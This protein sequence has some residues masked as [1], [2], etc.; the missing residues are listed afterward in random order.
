MGLLIYGFNNDFK[1]FLKNGKK[2]AVSIYIYIHTVCA[3]TIINTKDCYF[4]KIFH[5]LSK[6]TLSENKNKQFWL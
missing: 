5:I 2:L 4:I 6:K 1:R 3:Y